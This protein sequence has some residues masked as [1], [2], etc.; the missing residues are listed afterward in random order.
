MSKRVVVHIDDIWSSVSANKAAFDLFDNWGASSWSIIVPGHWFSDLV[1]RKHDIATYDL[2]VHLTLTSEWLNEALKWKPTLPVHE[3]SSLVDSNWYFW[4]E[5][6]DVLYK[7][8]PEEIRKELINQV[9]IAQKSWIDV[10]HIDSHMW[11]LLHEKL[12]FIYKELADIFKTQPFLVKSKPWEG[13][14]N[15]FYR[16]DKHIDGLINTWF[17]VLDNFDANSLYQW[18]KKYNLHCIDRIQSIKEWTTYFLLHVLGDDV[19]DTEKTPDYL[20]RQNE[21]HFFGSDIVH[22]I[23]EEQSIK[24]ITMKEL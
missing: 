4:P 14:W 23:F 17:N 22:K 11:V 8:H 12:F 3:V 21:Y 19:V 18:E 2:W 15:W 7:A 6:D 10:S 1:A 5:V 13:L 9:I 16:C 20:A 24:K